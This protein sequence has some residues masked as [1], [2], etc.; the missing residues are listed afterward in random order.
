MKWREVLKTFV[1]HAT[2]RQLWIPIQPRYTVHPFPERQYFIECGE[3]C[4]V[5]DP[6]RESGPI[7]VG[8]VMRTQTRDPLNRFIAIVFQAR[9]G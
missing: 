5:G 3:V 8:D 1:G 4:R 7:L 2:A 9:C 6:Q